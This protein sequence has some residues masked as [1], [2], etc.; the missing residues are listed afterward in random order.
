MC[1]PQ[2]RCRDYMHRRAVV[3]SRTTDRSGAR[4]GPSTC[5]DRGSER[6]L[7]L[8]YQGGAV[9]GGCGHRRFGAADI[10]ER[11]ISSKARRI[12]VLIADDETLF[13]EA[14]HLLLETEPGFHVV[15]YASDGVEAVALA[16]RLKPDV[17]LLDLAM[18]RMQGLDALK[19]IAAGSMRVRTI[20]V[21]GSMTRADV[22]TALHHGA[23]GIVMK[24]ASA[25]LL[26]KSIRAVMNGQFW[27]EHE[28]VSD[29][30]AALRES[31]P[32]TP[33]Q[34]LLRPFNLTPREL[35]I[36][37]AVVEGHAN[38]EV[39]SRL[40]VTEPTVKHH[41]TSIFDKVGVSSRL[42]LALFAMHHGLV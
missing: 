15:G 22:L 4:S 7:D 13:R 16:R 25:D 3:Y 23:R 19:A 37:R 41:L 26:F 2:M 29:L 39:A 17:L 12:R 10:A 40:G 38:K 35:D 32:A 5:A 31:L 30:V 1:A 27:I 24:D 11:R 18:P 14:L 42:E 36:L 20:L 8:A 21:T 34:S 9:A 6:S 33:S 28:A